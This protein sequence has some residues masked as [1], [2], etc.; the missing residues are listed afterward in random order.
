MIGVGAFAYALA[1]LSLFVVDQGFDLIHV[2][3]EIAR[4]VYLLI[5]FVAFL[6]LAVLAA[7][8][9]DRM[10]KRLGGLNWRRL[11]QITYVLGLLIL[12]HYFQQTKAD[13]T[14]PTLYAG[15]LTWLLGYRLLAGWRGQGALGP[16]W[17]AVL[18]VAAGL[19]TLVGEAVGI[20][21]AFGVSPL[22][23]LGTAF[24]LDLGLRPGWTVMGAGLLV[25]VL[26]LV[27]G[28]SERRAARGRTSSRPVPAE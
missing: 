2:A 16:V 5:G 22:M 25:V 17:L 19:L 6:G 11:H 10:V 21:I 13:V 14:V 28:W 27:R 12:V 9:T 4:R 3:A 18:A 26:D 8:S 1:H 24:D 23:I 20:G 15:L 7:T